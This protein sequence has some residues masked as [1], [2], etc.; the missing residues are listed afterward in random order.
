VEVC[1]QAAFATG[2]CTA[3]WAERLEH[4][5]GTALDLGSTLMKRAMVIAAALNWY[6][7]DDNH[8]YRAVANW[9]NQI[10]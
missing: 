10:A 4:R 8:F 2:P 1:D 3:H 6:R 7:F 9:A 5:L